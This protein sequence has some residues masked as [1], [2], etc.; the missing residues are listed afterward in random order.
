MS[1]AITQASQEAV[2]ADKRPK[3][4]A[5]GLMASRLN[6]EPE[7]MKAALKGTVFKDC[8]SD[9]ELAALVVVCN[10]YNLNP[11][12]KEIY[13]FPA[14][15]GGIVPVVSVDGWIS[16]VNQHPQM[17]GIE[18][19]FDDPNGQLRSVTCRIYR[20]DRSRPVEITEYLSECKRNTDPWKM[21]HRM[22]RHKALKE[23][24]R[25]AFGFSGIVDEDEAYEIRDATPRSSARPSLADALKEE[26]VE[27]EATPIADDSTGGY[28]LEAA[29]IEFGP[30]EGG[31]P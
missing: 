31:Q 9:E 6:L 11:F 1:T 17:D 23:C 18:F 13:A 20:K 10:E 26:P 16:L 28:S 3:V 7:K 14:K 30:E 19:A 27:V 2:T 25:I 8:R 21:E 15:G 12:L 4:T 24:A 29:D 22:L 5:L